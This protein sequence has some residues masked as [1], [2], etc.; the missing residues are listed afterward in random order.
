VVF[1]TVRWV[2]MCPRPALRWRIVSYDR[3]TLAGG[4]DCLRCTFRVR[5][6]GNVPIQTQAPNAGD[7]GDGRVATPTMRR[8]CFLGNASARTHPFPKSR[9]AS[10]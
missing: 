10:E 5:N 9:G 4:D 1:D 3:T 6:T 7:P 2:K 8:E